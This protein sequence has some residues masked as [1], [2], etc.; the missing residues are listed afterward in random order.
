M[1]YDPRYGVVPQVA[2]W[3]ATGEKASQLDGFWS[4]F[5][6]HIYATNSKVK[7]FDGWV[8][9]PALIEGDPS[10]MGMAYG[11]APKKM[12]RLVR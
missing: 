7:G 6:Y 4:T 8:M 9:H 5:T 11:F 12:V 1:R 3:P 10:A 2:E